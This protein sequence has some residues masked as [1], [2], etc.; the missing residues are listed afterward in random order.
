MKLAHRLAGVYTEASLFL[1]VRPLMLRCLACLVFATLFVSAASAELYQW[2]D[3]QGQFHFSDKKPEDTGS[4]KLQLSNNGAMRDFDVPAMPPASLRFNGISRLLLLKPIRLALTDAAVRTDPVVGSYYFGPDC[5]SP[6]SAT[7]KEWRERYPSAD[8]LENGYAN[9]AMNEAMKKGLRRL[10]WIDVNTP[11]ASNVILNATITDMQF[12][13]CA[14]AARLDA[15]YGYQDF[16][17]SAARVRIK[18]TFLSASDHKVIYE[19]STEGVANVPAV[20]FQLISEALTNAFADAMQRLMRD[21]MIN[22]MMILP[23]GDVEEGWVEKARQLPRALYERYVLRPRLAEIVV[24]LGAIK[25][26]TTEYYLTNGQWPSDLG[27]VQIDAA[28]LSH[29]DRIASVTLRGQGEIVAD[30]SPAFGAGSRL[31][32]MPS[33]T[34]N[35]TTVLWQCTAM[36]ESASLQQWLEEFCLQ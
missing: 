23:E 14:R 20:D 31:I 33:P 9:T 18:W 26:I 25:P 8:P 13:A 27:Q 1:F 12:S 29:P 28:E 15:R 4:T 34:R 3:A 19:T 10:I 11:Q 36:I 30:I 32:L 5:V 16:K 22:K 21:E 7:L 6:T 17:H 35:G 2:K 24:L